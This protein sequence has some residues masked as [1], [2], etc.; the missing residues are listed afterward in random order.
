M[1]ETTQSVLYSSPVICF[2]GLA[3]HLAMKWLEARQLAPKGQEPG[4]FGYI[5]VVPAQTAIAVLST[6]AVFSLM[7]AMEWMN[8]G[9][10]FA[11]GYMGHSMAENLANR[12]SQVPPP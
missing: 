1:I 5:R 11:S 10:A 3:L 7:S 6:L 4:L 12:F 8:P 2:Y 9:A